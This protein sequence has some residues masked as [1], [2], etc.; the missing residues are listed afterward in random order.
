MELYD[1]SQ[2][3]SAQYKPPTLT[4]SSAPA[5]YDLSP[6]PPVQSSTYHLNQ[7]GNN[8]WSLPPGW[9]IAHRDS[10]GRMYYWNMSTGQTTW[11]HPLAPTGNGNGRNTT[12]PSPLFPFMNNT[13]TNSLS[14]ADQADIIRKRQLMET[15]ANAS[16][17]PD[18]HNC[19][20]IF[21][22]IV[23]PPLGIFALIH[24][25]LTYRSWGEGRYGDSHDHSKQAYT[26]AWWAIA[27]FVGFVV[28]HFILRDWN[29]DWN[30]FD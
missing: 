7:S 2:V 12:S 23:F 20:A 22:C 1:N 17:R 6:P 26:F 27:I 15:P 28:Y 14:P 16:K 29:W 24:S 5:D 18:S 8:E 9:K 21:S 10:D 30:F 3:S 11:C 13:N 19:C 4:Q 25:I